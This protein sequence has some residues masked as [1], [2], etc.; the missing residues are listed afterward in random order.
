ME[1]LEL[2]PMKRHCLNNMCVSRNTHTPT[3]THAYTKSFT[4]TVPVAPTHI[5]THTHTH[6]Q[7]TNVNNLNT[8]LQ[9]HTDTNRT[10]TH[11]HTHTKTHI[12]VVFPQYTGNKIE[13]KIIQNNPKTCTYKVELRTV[14]HEKRS[15]QAG[16][17][18]GRVDRRCKSIVTPHRVNQMGV[19]NTH[20]L[21]NSTVR[22]VL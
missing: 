5:H 19:H 14:T 20:S 2:P 13:Y 8:H 11:T 1:T 17:P 21:Y 9:A 3:H 16:L 18:Y 15:S 4:D 7:Q 12:R 6:T 22:W 10:H